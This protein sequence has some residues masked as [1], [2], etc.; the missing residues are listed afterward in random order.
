M[1]G[2]RNYVN[3]TLKRFHMKYYK[4]ISTQVIKGIY[5]KTQAPKDQ[6]EINEMSK[7]PYTQQLAV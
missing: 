2:S 7:V 4:A 3:E 1:L 6:Q 5:S